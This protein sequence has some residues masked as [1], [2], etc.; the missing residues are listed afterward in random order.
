MFYCVPALLPFLLMS[1]T[2][3]YDC[4][5]LFIHSSV[6]GLMNCFWIVFSFCLIW[7]MLLWTFRLQVFMWTYVFKSLGG[8][9]T[10]IF[11]PFLNWLIFKSSLYIL[12][13]WLLSEY[14]LQFFFSILWVVFFFMM[15]CEVSHL[16]KFL[17]AIF[18]CFLL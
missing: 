6:N 3:L 1:N 10:Q 5:I 4:P 14:D 15:S 12:D 8:M 18:I 13:I 7:I 11:C 2:P 9:S 17:L 16:L